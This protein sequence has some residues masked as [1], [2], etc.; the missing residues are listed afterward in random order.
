MIKCRNS[1]FSLLGPAFS[2]RCLLSPAV[3][4]HLWRT[5]SLPV[6]VSGLPSLPI[7]PTNLKSLEIFQR[8]VLRGFLKL[9]KSSPIPALHFL[10]GELPVEGLLHI[11]TLGLFHNICSNPTSTVMYILK[12]CK[13]SSTIWANHVQ[14]ICLK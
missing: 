11:L 3:Q 4:V 12:M 10:L 7:R 13:S 8:K 14:I 5:C 6:L 2:F 9:S 1:L